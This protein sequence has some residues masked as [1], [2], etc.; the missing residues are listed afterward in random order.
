MYQEQPYMGAVTIARRSPIT[1]ARLDEADVMPNDYKKELRSR[2]E[3]T[4]IETPISAK[5]R[6]RG[7]WSQWLEERKARFQEAHNAQ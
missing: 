1:G 2:P 6:I 4:T 5:A 7:E 3:A